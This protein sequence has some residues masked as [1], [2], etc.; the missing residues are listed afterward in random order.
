[1][2]K[3]G[4]GPHDSPFSIHLIEGHN[5][6]SDHAFP[7]NFCGPEQLLS[8]ASPWDDFPVLAGWRTRAEADVSL[9]HGTDLFISRAKSVCQRIGCVV[10]PTCP[11]PERLPVPSPGYNLSTKDERN[12][13][14]I[15]SPWT[16]MNSARDLASECL[17]LSMENLQNMTEANRNCPGQLI[18]LPD[19]SQLQVSILAPLR[20]HR[21]H[22]KE[23][24]QAKY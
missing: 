17:Q 12:P 20:L 4:N 18:F 1:M 24:T 2:S 19:L 22:A 3:A 10:S 7:Y 23:D 8:N 6:G 14:Q 11:P 5:I 21:W 15:L 13:H 9:L 16:T